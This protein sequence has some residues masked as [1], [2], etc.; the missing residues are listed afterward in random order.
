[1]LPRRSLAPGAS[2]GQDIHITIARVD[3]QELGS[4]MADRLGITL[5]G[6]ALPA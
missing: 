1:M 4:F 6:E 2:A 5:P 3:E